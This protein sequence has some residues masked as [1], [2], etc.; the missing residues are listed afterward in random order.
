[1]PWQRGKS[2]DVLSH[3]HDVPSH[4]HTTHL[5]ERDHESWFSPRFVKGAWSCLG[6]GQMTKLATASLFMG[7]I[8]ISDLLHGLWRC[9]WR[10]LGHENWSSK[11]GA[12]C[13][14]FHGKDH[15]PWSSPWA[16]S[17]EWSLTRGHLKSDFLVFSF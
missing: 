2:K 8:T 10:W 15:G 3:K 17:W 14:N 7:R 9:P 13:L 6:H 1:M 11:L 4:K 16:W 5:H 12:H